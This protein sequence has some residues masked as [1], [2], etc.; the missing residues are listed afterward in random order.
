M[1]NEEEQQRYAESLERL[2]HLI[3]SELTS[4]AKLLHDALLEDYEDFNFYVHYRRSV[5]S[6]INQIEARKALPNAPIEELTQII[7]K[8]ADLLDKDEELEIEQYL[9]LANEV[10]GKPFSGARLLSGL[11]FGV[12]LI[13]FTLTMLLLVTVPGP[14]IPVA[15]IGMVLSLIVYF[16]SIPAAALGEPS[17][18]SRDVAA[19]G[20]AAKQC[21][22]A[23][24]RHLGFFEQHKPDGIELVGEGKQ[25]QPGLNV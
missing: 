9:A 8:T 13:A 7:K 10:Q 16:G 6:L 25:D 17:G 15:I 5:R 21:K 1:A 24:K 4:K 12:G 11:M 22:E 19:I 20:N 18:L 23:D 14:L 3:K 2:E